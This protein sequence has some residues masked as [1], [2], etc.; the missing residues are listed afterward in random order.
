M[1]A[2]MFIGLVATLSVAMFSMGT[3]GVQSASNLSNATAARSAAES[4]LRWQAYRLLTMP[5][6]IVSEGKITKSVA[7]TKVWPGLRTNIKSDYAELTKSAEKSFHQE[8]T[9]SVFVEGVLVSCPWI[10]SKEIALDDSD[11]RFRIKMWFIARED[12]KP[13]LLR[14]MSMGYSGPTGR[15]DA[16]GD[17]RF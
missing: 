2:M 1:L 4:G 11:A 17:D 12:P 10:S 5:R 8:G 13:Q 16:L 9:D 7:I 15:R 3:L 6:P 14:V